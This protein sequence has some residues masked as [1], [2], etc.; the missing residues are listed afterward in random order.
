[1]FCVYELTK[2]WHAA[3]PELE[4]VF[5]DET[6]STN[7][8]A[9]GEAFSFSSLKLYVAGTQEAGKGRGGN[10][11][12]SPPKGAAL[13]CSWG[14]M[15]KDAPREDMSTL[16]GKELC[17]AAKHAWPGVEFWSKAPNDLYAGDKKIGGILVEYCTQGDQ[18]HL[19]IG[20]G[21]NIWAPP[22]GVPIASCVSA[23]VKDISPASYRRF[24]DRLLGSIK[25][26]FASS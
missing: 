4:A 1:M 11:W 13:L 15:A 14:G 12:V 7:T 21:L 23:F 10:V 20:I 17:T 9:M 16:V 6:A 25:G 8:L 26:L 5:L 2:A 19:V 18:H 24:L 3:Q 22:H